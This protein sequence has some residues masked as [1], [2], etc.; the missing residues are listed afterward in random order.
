MALTK[1]LTFG[2]VLKRAWFAWKN[3]GNLANGLAVFREHVD[4]PCT[5]EQFY[6]LML[7]VD[8]YN[9]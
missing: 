6:T 5:A 3:T 4:E 8:R 7:G 1:T 2:E 9:K